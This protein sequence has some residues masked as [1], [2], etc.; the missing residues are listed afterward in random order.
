MKQYRPLL[1]QE[2]G[3]S[4]LHTLLGDASISKRIK[5]QIKKITNLC[6]VSKYS[7]KSSETSQKLKQ[8]TKRD[9]QKE[10]VAGIV[11]LDGSFVPLRKGEQ[12][13]GWSKFKI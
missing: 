6:K 3:L 4:K 2:S 1:L 10:P 8:K 12:I 5:I 13:S 9:L 11:S 7:A